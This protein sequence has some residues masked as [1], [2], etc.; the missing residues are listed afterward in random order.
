M[1]KITKPVWAF[2][3]AHF[4]CALIWY[5]GIY[6][7]LKRKTAFAVVPGSVIGAIP[8]MVGYVA[9]G[10]SALDPQILAFAFFMFMWQIPHFWLLIMKITNTLWH[11]SVC[12]KW[13]F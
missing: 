13:T 9:A 1:K 11:F 3:F 6:T 2:Y 5:N 12:R 10:G 4:Y 8:P 7:P